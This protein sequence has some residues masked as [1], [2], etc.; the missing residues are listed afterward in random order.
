MPSVRA[1]LWLSEHF[2][3][4]SCTPHLLPFQ[5]IVQRSLSAKSL[6]HAKGG[7]VLGGY[8]KILPMFFIVMPGMISRA[9]F[10]GKSESCSLGVG[11]WGFQGVSGEWEFVPRQC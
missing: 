5:V 8:L 7:S 2:L 6:S 1:H 9:L 10:P 4:L 3:N 11:I